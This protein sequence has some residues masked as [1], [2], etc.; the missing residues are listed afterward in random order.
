MILESKEKLQALIL[1]PLVTS[2]SICEILHVVYPL[3][4]LLHSDIKIYFVWLL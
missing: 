3:Y 2:F 1:G 4:Y